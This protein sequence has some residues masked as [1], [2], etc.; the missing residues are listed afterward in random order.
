M[1]R[2]RGKPRQTHEQKT[3]ESQLYGMKAPATQA[4]PSAMVA[5]VLGM[6]QHC[7][8]L[9]REKDIIVQLRNGELELVG[10]VYSLYR[11]GGK[12]ASVGFHT[13]LKAIGTEQALDMYAGNIK[14]HV[15]L[16]NET[17]DVVDVYVAY[18]GDAREQVHDLVRGFTAKHNPDLVLYSPLN[19]RL[20]YM[21]GHM[22]IADS[23]IIRSILP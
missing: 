11:T 16:W 21:F 7:D 23:K 12:I 6:I 4:L 14:L 1:P 13:H 2:G 17:R 15:V 18:R 3:P 9:K 10:M 22:T 8:L 19:A 5:D 20:I